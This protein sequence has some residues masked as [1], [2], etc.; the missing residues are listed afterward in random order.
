MLFFNLIRESILFALNALVINKLRTFLS[1]LGISIGI[2]AIISVF[3][4]VDSLETSLRSSVSSLGDNVVFVQKWPWTFGPNYPWWKYMNRPIPKVE[5]EQFI[6]RKCKNAEATAFVLNTRKTIKY[7]SSSVQNTDLVAVS[8]DYEKVKALNIVEGR[9]FT[10]QESAGG[11]NIVIIGASI[12]NALFPSGDALGKT[13]KIDKRSATIIGI[14]KL[15]GEGLNIFGTTDNQLIIPVNFA[16]NF[17]DID[18]HSVD[19]LIMV[20]ANPGVSNK[21]LIDELTGIM[22]GIRKLKPTADDSFALNQTSLI[23]NQFEQLFSIVN[24][25]GW[26]IGIFSIL[27][28]GFGIANIMFV[29]VRERTPIIGIQKALGAKNYFILIQFLTESTVLSVVGG[30]VGLVVVYLGTFLG[31]AA[32]GMDITLTIGNTVMGLSIAAII[33]IIAGFIPSYTASRLNP[34]DAIRS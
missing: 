8:H 10:E 13:I 15:Q 25:A 33:G 21:Q 18:G 23:A 11:K 28:G 24:L 30:I 12:A 34:V 4:V 7:L 1:L 32:F 14:L 6:Q 27:V 2:F 29:S 19:P 9:Y 22:R 3:T 31:Q 5:E 20:K 26:I 16:R 17:I